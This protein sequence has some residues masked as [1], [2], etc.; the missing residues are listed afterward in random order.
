MRLQVAKMT[1]HTPN[2]MLED[3][4][5]IFFYI[6]QYYFYNYLFGYNQFKCNNVNN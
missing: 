2:N 6:N 4:C 1:T 3:L 5:Y